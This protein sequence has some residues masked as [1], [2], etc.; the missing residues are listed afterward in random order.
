MTVTDKKLNDTLAL[1]HSMT[2]EQVNAVVDAIKLRRTRIHR[3][4]V[5]ELNVG[6]K[7]KFTGRGNSIVTGTIEKKAIKNVVIDTGAG[8]W[9]VPASMVTILEA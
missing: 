3:D 7:V 1:V 2:T 4:A 9:R 6:D 5:H 8:K